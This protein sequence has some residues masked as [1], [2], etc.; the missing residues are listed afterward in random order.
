MAKILLN[1]VR[2]NSNFS[3]APQSR[4]FLFFPVYLA[5]FSNVCLQYFCSSMVL[6]IVPISACAMQ[7][8]RTCH[9]VDTLDKQFFRYNQSKKV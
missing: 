1:D 6:R 8:H 4:F 9:A 3:T 5:E 2:K 7:Y